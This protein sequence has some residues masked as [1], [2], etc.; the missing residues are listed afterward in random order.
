[1][2]VTFGVECHHVR[3]LALREAEDPAIFAKARDAGVVMMTK[4]EDFV[5]LVE[6]RGSPPQIVWVT[7]GNMSN[8]H[9]QS[10]LIETLQDAMLLIEKGEPIVEICRRKN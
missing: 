4:D 2:E 9:F 6:R 8:A 10:L 7:S 5:R 1:M 3:D